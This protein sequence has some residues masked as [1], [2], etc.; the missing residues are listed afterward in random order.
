MILMT[1]RASDKELPVNE[2][3]DGL[4]ISISTIN[5]DRLERVFGTKPCEK[6]KI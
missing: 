3:R 5:T 2:D 6:I 1:L 4:G